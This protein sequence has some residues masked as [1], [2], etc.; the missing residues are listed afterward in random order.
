MLLVQLILN[1]PE[2]IGRILR[3]TPAW[4]WGL[5]AALLALGLSQLRART[6]SLAR[7]SILPVGMSLFSAFGA[8]AAFGRSPHTAAAALAW[9]AAAAA[10][11]AL[12]APGRADAQF[13]PAT[14]TYRITG[15]AV[16]L[17]LIMGIFLVKYGVGVELAMAP[18]LAQDAQYAVIVS[19]MYGAFTGVFVGR[20]M[21]LWKLA[22]RPAV[23]AQPA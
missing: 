22:A 8:Y 10:F 14:R 7:V 15:S 3:S 1:H 23:F 20:A 21:R 2:A 5:L 12:V 13:D 11:A 19:A 9:L 18:R 4:V 6:V 17:L 16:P